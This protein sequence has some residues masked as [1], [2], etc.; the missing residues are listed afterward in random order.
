ML[1]GQ[2]GIV[3]GSRELA[4]LRG[5]RVAVDPLD[6]DFLT[7]VVIEDDTDALA[8][9]NILCTDALAA[10]RALSRDRATRS[11]R[12]ALMDYYTPNT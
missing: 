3:E 7:F 2:T 5:E 1:D 6:P 10:C 8:R 11:Q 9:G 4:S 12:P